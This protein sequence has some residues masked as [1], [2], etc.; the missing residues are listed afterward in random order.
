MVEHLRTTEPSLWD[1]F[2]STQKRS[3]EADAVRLDLLKS[4]Y[5]FDAQAQPEPSGLVLSGLVAGGSVVI[6]RWRRR[7]TTHVVPPAR[8]TIDNFRP[9]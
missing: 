5:R 9:N 4:T 3:D 2:S 6:R 1:W 7:R 8:Q